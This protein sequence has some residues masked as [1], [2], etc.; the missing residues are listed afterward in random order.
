[1]LVSVVSDQIS[2]AFQSNSYWSGNNLF[3]VNWNGT[4]Y[5]SLAAW[6]QVADDQE[7]LSAAP[8]TAYEEPMLA[9]DGRG[10][11]LRRPDD[12][13]PVSDERLKAV[14]PKQRPSKHLP[15]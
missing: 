9:D 15:E 12:L 4:D 14:A 11:T 8:P 3:R 7:R 6:L 13:W 1:M 10:A 2:I 5:D